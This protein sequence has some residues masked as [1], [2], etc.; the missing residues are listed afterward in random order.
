MWKTLM[1]PEPK[2]NFTDIYLLIFLFFF[3]TRWRFIFRSRILKIL[4]SGVILL[5]HFSIKISPR[6][7][8]MSQHEGS[9]PAS[10][11][12]TNSG[13]Q[14]L[15]PLSID[16]FIDLVDHK[17]VK[18]EVIE[19]VNVWCFCAVMLRLISS[20]ISQMSR[21]FLF[22]AFAHLVAPKPNGVNDFSLV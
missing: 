7:H 9:L 22:V 21:T 10:K 13:G 17:A 18:C 1:N 5:R 4:Q 16:L 15:N 20:V 3:I 8:F 19:P 14:K 6:F 12:E 11:P 2:W